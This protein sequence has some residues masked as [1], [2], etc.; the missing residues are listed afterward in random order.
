M[1]GQI[2]LIVSD[3]D[4]IIMA[5]TTIIVTIS[6]DIIKLSSDSFNA[7][8]YFQLIL[9]SLAAALQPVLKAL[10]LITGILLRCTP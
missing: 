6:G 5:V 3:N 9:T 1:I 10:H 7:L 2:V 8:V 4:T